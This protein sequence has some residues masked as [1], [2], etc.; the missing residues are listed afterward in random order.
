MIRFSSINSEKISKVQKIQQL[1]FENLYAKYQ[2]S[3]SPFNE[4]LASL[5]DKYHRPHNHFLFIKNDDTTIGFIRVVTDETETIARIAPIAIKPEFGGQ[6]FG[7]E[8]MLLIEKHFPNVKEWQL[9]T[10]LQEEKLIHL[11][12]KLGY[13][14]LDKVEPVKPLMDIVYFVKKIK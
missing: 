2:D 10:I 5:T 14:K 7:T 12:S 8:A 3:G 13:Q 4:S 6:G 9:D 11:Y 1:A